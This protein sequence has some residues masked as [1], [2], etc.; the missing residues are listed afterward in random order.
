[1][2]EETGLAY[3]AHRIDIRAIENRHCNDINIARI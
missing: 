2:L 3:E 1:M